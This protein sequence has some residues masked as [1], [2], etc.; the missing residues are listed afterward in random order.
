MTSSYVPSSIIKESLGAVGSYCLTTSTEAAA[1][2]SA[3]A[4]YDL[5]QWR[6]HINPGVQVLFLGKLKTNRIK[7]NRSTK[8][9]SK[10][11]LCYPLE[12]GLWI[13]LGLLVQF[14]NIKKCSLIITQNAC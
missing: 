2:K 14:V 7:S 6:I 13:D 12:S 3:A 4:R 5:T 8:S 11:F 9:H 10:K 1:E